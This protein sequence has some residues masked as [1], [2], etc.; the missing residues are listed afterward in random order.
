V[1]FLVFSSSTLI[2]TGA[3]FGFWRLLD[4]FLRLQNQDR[5]HALSRDRSQEVRLFCSH[6]A[7]EF[8][9]FAEQT[10]GSQKQKA[11]Q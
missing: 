10:S 11:T 1:N 7:M 9:A 3:F 4:A 5:L 2:G 6:D 8:Q